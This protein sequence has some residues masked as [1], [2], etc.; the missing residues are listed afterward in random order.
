VSAA[1]VSEELTKWEAWKEENGRAYNGVEE[2]AFRR[3]VFEANLAEAAI[4]QEQNP[5]AE[6]GAT[7]FSDWTKDEMKESLTNYVPSGEVLPEMDLSHLPIEVAASQDWTGKYTTPVKDQGQ[8]GSCWAFSAVE[9]IESDLMREHGTTLTLSVQELVDCTGSKG[10]RNGC[11]GGFPSAAYQVVEQ[12]GG[13]EAESSYPYTA[14]N[15]NCRF[16]ESQVAA[17]VSAYKAVGQGSESAMKSY[18]SATGPLSVCVDANSWNS[19]RGGI[20]TSCGNSVDHCVQVVGFGTSG[21]TD[22]WKVRNSWGGSWGES[23]H[24]RLAI[25]RNLCQIDSSPSAVTASAAVSENVQV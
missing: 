19:Y 15:G 17:K 9:Q 20:M 10:K 4:L 25:G 12:L 11:Q 13:I 8:C 2:D 3:S 1:A 6:F 21:S 5:L 18:V 24:I 16:S 14:R 23:G 7:R 22:Y